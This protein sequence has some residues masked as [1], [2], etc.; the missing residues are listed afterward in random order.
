MKHEGKAMVLKV[1]IASAVLLMLAAC[2]APASAVDTFAS[3]KETY[4][5]VVNDNGARFDLFGNDTYYYIFSKSGGGFKAIH[6]TNS[7]SD[8]DGDVYTGQS[9]LDTFYISDT[10]TDTQYH[11]DIILMFA[12]P[13]SANYSNLNLQLDVA[14]YQW[15]PTGD[16]TKPTLNNSNYNSSTLSEV[17]D[18]NDFLNGTSE[19]RP[20]SLVDY[21][22]Y[23][24]Q[25]MSQYEQFK[26]ML[27]D[28]YAGSV[29]QTGLTDNGMVEVTYEITGYNGSAY[30]D[31]YAW[32]NQSKQGQG[33]SWTNRVVD[34]GSSGWAI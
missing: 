22:V 17:F 11:D 6:I 31:A 13:S 10:S 28:L 18:N 7:T 2:V 20:A 14:G 21:P 19:W 26:F 1:A 32:N 9:M 12:V 33:V 25:N 5:P 16:G 23:Y 29:N 4:V 27:I 30:F 34:T 15:T 8:N 3:Y 24:S